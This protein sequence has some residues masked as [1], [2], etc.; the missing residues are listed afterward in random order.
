MKTR[1]RKKICLTSLLFFVIIG[2]V[3][4]GPY[5]TSTGFSK[6]KPDLGLWDV[7]QDGTIRATFVNGY[8]E[9][10]TV[11]EI[12]FVEDEK[13]L[14]TV[15]LDTDVK[16]MH[17]FSIVQEK[18]NQKRASGQIYN[19]FIYIDYYPNSNETFLQTEVGT[20]RAPVDL[21]SVQ[22]HESLTNMILLILGIFSIPAIPIASVGLIL[23]GLSPLLF[24]VF[25]LTLA[26]FYM[27]IKMR[28]GYF[29]YLSIYIIYSIVVTI[30]QIILWQL[31][32]YN[33]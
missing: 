24:I 17:N 13:T 26:F 16:P 8:G 30:I 29:K 12:R 10:I 27:K 28:G 31:G 18:C 5:L 33:M 6:I 14:C 19:M 23:Y 20:I 21:E 25:L 2:I 15:G 11:R 32:F 3:S 7:K 4:A 22:L 1:I 9:D